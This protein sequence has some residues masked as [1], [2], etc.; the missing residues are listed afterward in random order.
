MLGLRDNIKKWFYEA[1]ALDQSATQELKETLKRGHPN[2]ER[3]L[4]NM[5]GQ[6]ME[7]EKKCQARGVLLKE[8]TLQDFTY[9]MARYFMVGMEG[10]AKR[11][12]ESDLA[13][14]A[15]EAEASKLKEFDDFLA[16]GEDN[17]FADS[18]VVHDESIDKARETE[19]ER[20]ASLSQR[21]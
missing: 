5:C 7:A 9:D 11:R 6:I 3:F 21:A 2:L 14:S 19:L 16:G 8:K 17:E 10:E 13:K 18:G 15:R 4:D 12:Y 20:K 1:V